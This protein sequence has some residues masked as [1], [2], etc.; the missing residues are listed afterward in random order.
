MLA[1]TYL[2]VPLFDSGIEISFC[3]ITNIRSI[4]PDICSEKWNPFRIVL[5]VYFLWMQFESKMFRKKILDL[6]DTRVEIL[7]IMM[8]QNKIIYISAIVFDM[9]IFFNKYIQRMQIQIRKY[10]TREVSDR[11]TDGFSREE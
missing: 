6:W 4:R 1:M 7:S 2:F 10:L 11:Q 3:T 8:N 9:Q 5:K